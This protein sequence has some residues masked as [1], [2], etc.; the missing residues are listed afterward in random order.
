MG[1]G[2]RM[3]RG[4]SW[5]NGKTD[6]CKCTKEDQRS[7]D[8]ENKQTRS[9]STLAIGFSRVSNLLLES[10]LS[11]EFS[12]LRENPRDFPPWQILFVE[13]KADQNGEAGKMEKFCCIDLAA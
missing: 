8:L 4:K 7:V 11:H 6:T 12:R 9:E 3:D 13:R 1:Y 10:G 2:K 5:I